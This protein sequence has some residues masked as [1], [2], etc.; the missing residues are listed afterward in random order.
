LLHSALEFEG[1]VGKAFLDRLACIG[2]GYCVSG[3]ADCDRL[4]LLRCYISFHDFSS[5]SAGLVTSFLSFDIV[6]IIPH[7][8]WR[9]VRGL[10]RYSMAAFGSR[11]RLTL[12]GSSWSRLWLAWSVEVNMDSTFERVVEGWMSVWE[13]EQ[14]VSLGSE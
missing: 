1:A 10:S 13:E 8:L 11:P 4:S 7:A 6:W 12:A 5:F 14:V 2:M 9:R 3:M